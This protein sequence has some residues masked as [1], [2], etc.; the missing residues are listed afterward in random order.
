MDTM[1]LRIR[2]FGGR[3]SYLIWPD[4]PA[5]VQSCLASAFDLAANG[6]RFA[7]LMQPDQRRAT[8]NH[9]T[10]ML[11]FLDEVPRRVSVGK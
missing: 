1:C 2:R 5:S 6:K 10:L 11:N 7:V 9:V 4:I 8:K 3:R